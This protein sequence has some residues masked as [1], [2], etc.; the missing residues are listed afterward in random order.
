MGRSFMISIQRPTR[1]SYRWREHEATAARRSDQPRRPTRS[2][3]APVDEQPEKRY[4][5]RPWRTTPKKPCKL[6]MLTWDDFEVPVMDVVQSMA[7][8]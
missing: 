5:A 7:C 3:R 1:T 4:D 6:A 2:R 8:N